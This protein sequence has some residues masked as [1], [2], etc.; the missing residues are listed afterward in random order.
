MHYHIP[1]FT[2]TTKIQ[3]AGPPLS[4][5]LRLAI[6]S[7]LPFPFFLFKMLVCSFACFHLYCIPG[8]HCS[9]LHFSFLIVNFIKFPASSL[10]LLLL[11]LL[12]RTEILG[13]LTRGSSRALS[14][15]GR[16]TRGLYIGLSTNRYRRRRSFPF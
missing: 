14:I 7:I 12:L 8:I 10:C 3:S 1:R 6:L 2:K 15:N 5:D 11:L 9:F 16:Q 13:T 4:C